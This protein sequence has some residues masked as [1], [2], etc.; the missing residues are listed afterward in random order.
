MKKLAIA[1]LA[2]AL[3]TSTALAGTIRVENHDSKTYTVELKCSGSSK[4]IEIRAST[5]TS[6]T[7]HSS[8]KE[9]EIVGGN[10]SFPVKKLED[11][12]KW[13]INNGKAEKN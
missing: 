3:L 12:Q 1:G 7:F 9:C 8:A 10:L 5:T 11:G 4:S 6:Y 13:K 2:T